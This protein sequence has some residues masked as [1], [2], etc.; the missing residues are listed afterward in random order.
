MY[1]FMKSSHSP[2]LNM[3]GTH[4]DFCMNMFNLPLLPLC[5][6]NPRKPRVWFQ[7]CHYGLVF[8]FLEFCIMWVLQYAL[9][10]F[11]LLWFFFPLSNY[12]EIHTSRLSVSEMHSFIVL[13]SIPVYVYMVICLCIYLL[14]DIWVC[15]QVSS[16]TNKTSMNIYL[17][18]FICT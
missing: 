5:T 10:F 11:G 1:T 17:Q 9:F 8:I 4:K 13:S 3:S 18:V 6:P 14:M 16:I 2:I 15:F 7:F 12:L